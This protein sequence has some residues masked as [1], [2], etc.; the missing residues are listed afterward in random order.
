MRD[1]SIRRR[2]LAVSRASALAAMAISMLAGPALAEAPK[3]RRGTGVPPTAKEASGQAD[4]EAPAT[5]RD[6]AVTSSDF[7]KQAPPSPGV[8][9]HRPEAPIPMAAPTAPQRAIPQPALDDRSYKQLRGELVERIPHHTP[10]WTNHQASDPGMHG[11]DPESGEVRFGDGAHG[12]R[13][14]MGPA[15]VGGQYRS[16]AG[17]TGAL[18]GV[19]PVPG[20]PDEAGEADASKDAK[21]SSPFRLQKAND[22]LK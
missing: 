5:R 13:P 19:P 9:V 12:R 21:P 6:R 7:Q 1:L 8:P 10:E 4:A 15:N 3:A 14:P 22:E 17:R 16:G 11:L 20:S 18:P 2:P